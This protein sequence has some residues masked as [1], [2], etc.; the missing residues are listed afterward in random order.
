VVEANGAKPLTD[1]LNE[2]FNTNN[3]SHCRESLITAGIKDKSI[4]NNILKSLAYD[5]DLDIRK[6]AQK[7]D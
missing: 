4:S 5:S 7:L 1:L 6:L 2:I 3:C